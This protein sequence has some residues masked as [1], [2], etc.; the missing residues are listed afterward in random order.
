[1]DFE[2]SPTYIALPDHA[3]PTWLNT[4]KALPPAW[5]IAPATGEIFEGKES[6]YQR[7]QAWGLF[8]GFAVVQG[9]VWKDRILRWQF[10]CKAHGTK[11][12]NKRNLE[13]RK[14]KNEE[15]KVVSDR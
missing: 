6:C 8:Q 10:I 9:R 13:S 1:M 11:T 5:L 7:L 4:I 3:K 12:E 2:H 15:G 14:R